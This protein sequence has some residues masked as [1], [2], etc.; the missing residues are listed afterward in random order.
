MPIQAMM[1]EIAGDRF[2]HLLLYNRKSNVG[3]RRQ[4]SGRKSN[5]RLAVILGAGERITIY[6]LHESVRFEL[7]AVGQATAQ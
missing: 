4:S 7:V 2:R 3:R 1:K 5:Y 6:L